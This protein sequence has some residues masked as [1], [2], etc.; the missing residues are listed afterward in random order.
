VGFNG[1]Q[2]WAKAQLGFLEVLDMILI[3]IG[4]K[5][6]R[7]KLSLLFYFIFFSVGDRVGVG[8]H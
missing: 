6:K 7:K 3:A 4:S 2:R 8:D 5:K 1:R